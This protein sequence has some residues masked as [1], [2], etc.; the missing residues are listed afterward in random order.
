[1]RAQFGSSDEE[2]VQLSKE[3]HA[4]F[5]DDLRRKLDHRTLEATCVAWKFESATSRLGVV[6]EHVQALGTRLGKPHI[7]VHCE[8]TRL[9]LPP[10]KW[11]SFWSV[12]AH[13]VRNVVDHGVQSVDERRAAGKDERTQIHLSLRHQGGR[14][15]LT[16]QDDGPG[17]DEARI[18]ERAKSLGLPHATQSELLQALFADGVSSRSQATATSGRGVGLGAVRHVV[19]ELGGRIDVHSE[20]GRGVRFQF[21]FPESML[22]EEPKTHSV[23]PRQR[24]A[25]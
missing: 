10:Q 22:W 20:L 13:V 7:D 21:V 15:I 3:E 4:A 18:S 16:I 2:Q 6:A 8:P 12:F 5:L 14:V 24:L 9:R 1:V 19:D 25:S 17:V 23:P 11:R